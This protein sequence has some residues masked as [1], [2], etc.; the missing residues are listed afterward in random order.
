VRAER[1]RSTN[2]AHEETVLLDRLPRARVEDV[3]RSNVAQFALTLVQAPLGVGKSSALHGALGDRTGVAWLDAKPWHR[4]AFAPAL[5]APIRAIRPDFGRLTLGAATAGASGTHLGATFAAELTHVD[6][7][8]VLAIDD[9]QVFADDPHFVAFADALCAAI[10]AQ[11][12]I[13]LCGRSLP[14]LALGE[15]FVRR[16]A[17]TVDPELFR[18]DAGEIASFAT[19]RGTPIPPERA[20]ELAASS[21]G[22]AAGIVLALSDPSF[23]LRGAAHSAAAAYLSEQLVPAL[24]A[25]LVAFLEE[26]SVFE[27]LDLRVLETCAGLAPARA[28]IDGLRRGGALVSELA[29]GRFRV[30]PLLRELAFARLAA[31][32][33]ASRAHG[34]AADA[35][36]RAGELRAAL[37]HAAASESQT[38]AAAFLGKYADAAAATGDDER[39]RGVAAKIEPDGPHADVRQYVEALLDKARGLSEARAKF[40]RAAT[41]ADASGNAALAFGARAQMLE[42]DLARLQPCS[43]GAIADLLER[44]GRL[45]LESVARATMLRGWSEAVG[46]DFHAALA[47]I[48]PLARRG[49]AVARFNSAILL[50][51]VQT[52]LG[53]FEAAE[54]TLDELVRLLENDDRVVLQALA[55]IWLARLSLTWGHTTVAADA[56]FGAERLARALDLHANEAALYVALTEVA[57][58]LGDRESTVRFAQ[59]AQSR[60]DFAWYAA[61]VDRV[62]AFAQIGLARAA[63]LGHENAIAGDLAVRAARASRVPSAQRA[64]LLAEGCFYTLLSDPAAA[65]P[66]IAAAHAALAAAHAVDAG[67]AVALATAADL[68]AFLDTADGRTPAP[69]MP[70]EPSFRTLVDRQR[71]LVTLELAGVAVSNARRGTGG[72]AAFDAALAAIA[73]DGP[74]FEIRLVRAYASRFIRAERPRVPAAADAID[75]T[76]REVEILALLVDG[77]TNKEIAQRLSVSPR[78]VETHVERVLG[79]LDVRSRSRAIAKALRLGIVSFDDAPGG[80]ASLAR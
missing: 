11:V 57:T 56:A 36:A 1:E 3:L 48:A 13:V 23:S 58:H 55:L 26:S 15:L 76:P 50:A 59:R 16:Q 44:A 19:A 71:G 79:K 40:S 20:R 49:D 31:R 37:F 75:L 41:A 67:D 12:R 69:Y 28:R 8:L 62:R 10:P 2:P 21:N 73:Q 32:G 5:V 66:G 39:V 74:R 45:D 80:P 77:F 9:A 34:A 46:H 54:A 47:T 65:A 38:A 29:A 24:P 61:D 4:G 78:T 63:F 68:L 72:T 42:S 7:P 52:A 25:D 60:A 35:Y 27:T 17:V 33:G 14:A 6:E 30:H 53:T 43:E 22:W 18:F 64:V 51:Y 70:S